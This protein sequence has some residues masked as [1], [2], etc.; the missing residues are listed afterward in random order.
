MHSRLVAAVLLVGCAVAAR[1]E[2]AAAPAEGQRSYPTLKLGGF[3]DVNFFATDDD[4]AEVTSGFTHGQFVLHF[5]GAIAPR[6]SYFAE[7]SLAAR[8]SDYKVDLERSIIK[9]EHSDR[10]K[11]SFGKYHTPINWWNTQF[12]HGQWLQTTVSRP[13]MVRFGGDYIPVHFVGGLVEGQAPG[14]GITWGYQFGVGN[15]RSDIISRA[16]DGG[17]VNDSRAWLVG[18]TLRPDKAY[19]LQFGASYYRDDLTL[20]DDTEHE[21][22]ITAVHAVWTKEDPELIAEWA[23]VDHEDQQTGLEHDHD[24]WYGQFAWRIPKG[25]ARWKPYVRYERISVDRSDPVFSALRDRRGALVGVRYD[26]KDFV[27][28]KIEYRHQRTDDLEY[29]DGGHAQVSFTF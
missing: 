18:F 8:S 29:V 5:N 28:I 4:Q 9:F 11:I 3:A 14:G 1:A 25:H 6:V 10:F 26:L 13:E 12:H 22:G 24:A 17:D 7:V 21:E 23:K 2:E 20:G 19:P 15:G 16:G 27:A